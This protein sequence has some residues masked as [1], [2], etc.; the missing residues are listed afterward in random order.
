MSRYERDSDRFISNQQAGYFKMRDNPQD[1]YKRAESFSTIQGYILFARRM[2]LCLRL[3]MGVS[4]EGREGVLSLAQ[5]LLTFQKGFGSVKARIRDDL[6]GMMERASIADCGAGTGS[7]LSFIEWAGLPYPEQ[8]IMVE[9]NEEYFVFLKNRIEGA[10]NT[11]T[12]SRLAIV[13]K[14]V[15]DRHDQ[16]EH[17]VYV[18]Q[19][20]ATGKQSQIQLINSSLQTNELP[21]A[22]KTSS[23]VFV[24]VSK[25][26][27]PLEFRDLVE[28]AQDNFHPAGKGITAFNTQGKK[29]SLPQTV[30]FA[31][32]LAYAGVKAFHQTALTGRPTF[33]NSYSLNEILSLPGDAKII[34][35]F[36]KAIIVA[37]QK[38]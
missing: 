8:L 11:P 5:D 37:L 2:E 12:K 14:E 3:S 31:E 23:I 6:Q 36:G 29:D 1:W 22:S 34:H 9:P 26:Y 38:S 24:G 27:K 17:V 16:I 30:A 25:Y 32:R 10:V 13:G 35:N 18:V 19:D 21:V 33:H 15:H 20:K 28:N 7:I 4:T